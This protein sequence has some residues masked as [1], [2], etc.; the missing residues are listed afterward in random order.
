MSAKPL[1]V[2]IV[3]TFKISD[4]WPYGSV[5]DA[6]E[7]VGDGDGH[8]GGISVI[9]AFTRGPGSLTIGW[10]RRLLVL[11]KDLLSYWLM[12]TSWR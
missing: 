5:L 10:V 6:G 1:S 8:F 2:Y 4:F 7:S 9:S 3:Q 12:K 11:C